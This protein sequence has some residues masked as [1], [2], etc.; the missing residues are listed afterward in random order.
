M[1]ATVTADRTMRELTVRQKAPCYTR[2]GE[3]K[4]YGRQDGLK[5]VHTFKASR[6]INVLVVLDK[7]WVT[8][9]RP[10]KWLV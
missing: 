1:V 6:L 7:R 3:G 9:D 5:D 4:I 10:V 8:E 2:S